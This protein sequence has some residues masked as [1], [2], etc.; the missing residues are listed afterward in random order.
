VGTIDRFFDEFVK[1]SATRL[2]LQEWPVGWL[3]AFDLTDALTM[4]LTAGADVERLVLALESAPDPAAA[5][6][7]AAV[8]RSVVGRT[9]RLALRSAYLEEEKYQSAAQR[10]GAWLYQPAIQARIESAIFAVQD[11]RLQEI[12]SRTA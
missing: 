5:V 4:S 7:F 2:E 9:D 8:R 10:L 11:P 3:P 6:H 12:L 1:F